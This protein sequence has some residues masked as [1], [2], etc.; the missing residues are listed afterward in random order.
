LTGRDGAGT[1]STGFTNLFAHKDL[2]RPVWTTVA[3]T[4]TAA[5]GEL[6]LDDAEQVKTAST[7]AVGTWELTHTIAVQNGIGQISLYA[8]AAE[9]YWICNWRTGAGDQ[10]VVVRDVV[11]AAWV[12]L[13]GAVT[14]P[15][16]ANPHVLKTTRDISGNFEIFFDNVSKGIGTDM[17]TTTFDELHIKAATQIVNYDNL[18]VY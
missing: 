8:A 13:S 2:F 3:G 10:N 9:K 17:T 14:T 18:K 7:F 11:D 12:I 16:D 1:V 5:G 4:P 6:V 15:Y